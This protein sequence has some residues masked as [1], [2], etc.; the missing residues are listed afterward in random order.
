M[1]IDTRL[2]GNPAALYAGSLYLR[3]RLGFEVDAAATTL[4][5]AAGEARH[6]WVGSAGA[7]FSDRMTGAAGRADALR[8]EV[9]ATAQ[10]MSQYADVLISAQ[11]TML[12]ARQMASAQGLIVAGTMILD[13]YSPDPVVRQQQ[14]VAYAT[15]VQQVLQA[16]GL[17][18]TARMIAQGR[19][20]VARSQPPIRPGDVIGGTAGGTA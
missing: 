2:D 3:D 10:T 16:R 19:R 11:G 20:S 1:P 9:D 18:T 6:G 13:P 7:T 5:T 17:M 8:S 15:A 4:R 12:M 14:Q